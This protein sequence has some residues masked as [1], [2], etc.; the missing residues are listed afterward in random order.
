MRSMLHIAFL[1]AITA[2]NAAP[3]PCVT[4][5][6]QLVPSAGPVFLASYPGT[7]IRELKDAAFLYDNAAATIALIG[8]NDI[9]HARRIGD[10]IL[11][12]QDDDRFWHDGRLRNAYLAGAPASPVKLAGWWDA[13]LNKWVEDRYQVG[14]D[15]GNQAWAMLALLALD[16]A[17]H[18]PRYRAGARRIGAWLERWR[19]ARGP[20]GFIGGVFG[21]EP[22]PDLL[23]WK[24]TEHNTDLA[25]AFR[26]LAQASGDEH[27]L[28]DAA[29]AEAMVRASWLADCRCFAAGTGLDGATPNRFLALDAQVFPLLALDDTARYRAVPATLR[30]RLA[31]DGGYAYSEARAGLW[32]EGTAQ[33]ALLM[34]VL[35]RDAE[36][37]ALDRAIAA[38]RMPDGAYYAADTAAQATGFM[39]DTDPT[40][41]RGYFHIPAL[42]PLAWAAL[43][44]RGFN[45]FR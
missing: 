35:H 33:A 30:K 38:M 36:A 7:T 13:K 3:T 34:R 2:A 25:A 32:T 28:A 9:A 18:D 17:T 39:L 31:R 22:T 16:R 14:S 8:C 10:A 41:P 19:D 1:A 24:S 23:T 40:Q 12:A 15:T 11:A 27:W 43:A 6:A 29:A 21:H 4:L 45:P 44:E 5:A 26:A 37:A 42:A 20:G